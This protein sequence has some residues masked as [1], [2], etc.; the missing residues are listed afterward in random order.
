[1]MMPGMDGP[2]TVAALQ[3]EG[4]SLPIVACSGLRS[5]GQALLPGVACFLG[6]PYSDQ[7]LLGAIHEVLNTNIHQ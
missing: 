1:M 2:A 5:S 4:V 7:Q 3:A 6:K